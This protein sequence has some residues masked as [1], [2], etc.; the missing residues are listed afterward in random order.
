MGHFAAYIYAQHSQ[1][2]F[3]SE[4]QE[5]NQRLSLNKMHAPQKCALLLNGNHT[6]LN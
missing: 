4:A 1:A 3:E 2:E 5:L 6:P